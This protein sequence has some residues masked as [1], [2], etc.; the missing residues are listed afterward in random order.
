M[1]SVRNDMRE[2]QEFSPRPQFEHLHLPSGKL[3]V[4]D[5]YMLGNQQFL[6]ELRSGSSNSTLTPEKI[7]IAIGKFGGSTIQLEPGHW[8]V[9]RDPIEF[10]LLVSPRIGDAYSIPFAWTDAF[11]REQIFGPRLKEEAVGKV[12]VDTRCIVFLD[13][14][15]LSN[16][17]VLNNYGAMRRSGDDKSARDLLRENGAA[18][19]YGFNR[20][21][22]E[23]GLFVLDQIGSVALWPDIVEQ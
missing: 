22:D 14:N 9:Y 6:S 11:S 4:I 2:N 20:D 7:D 19:R 13:C 3:A 12:F 18:V 10:L 5:Q 23:L 15:L 1:D 21:G 8:V 17:D 16:A